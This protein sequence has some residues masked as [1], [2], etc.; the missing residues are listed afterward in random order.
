M[1]K[2][3]PR[4]LGEL[5]VDFSYITDEQLKDALEQQKDSD[6]KLGELLVELN[7][8]N[9]SNLIQ[10]LEFQ[11][12]VP[13]VRLSDYIVNSQLARYIPEQIARRYNLVAIEKEDDK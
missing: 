7:Y 4:K 10:V 13:H 2:K 6:R 8:I 1:V 3:L 12:G 5:L 11:L 9:E